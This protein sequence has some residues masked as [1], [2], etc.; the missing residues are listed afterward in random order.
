MLT[1]FAFPKRE[2]EMGNI[3]PSSTSVSNVAQNQVQISTRS[4]PSN[5]FVVVREV[6]IVISNSSQYYQ[7]QYQSQRETGEKARYAEAFNALGRECA[8]LGGNMVLAT[9]VEVKQ[10]GERGQTLI[11]HCTGTACIVGPTRAVTTSTSATRAIPTATA[12]RISN[13]R[14]PYV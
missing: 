13:N 11:I 9:Q 14:T 10:Y 2:R 3:P 6:G 5:G 1:K 7:S 12:T 4:D 8:A